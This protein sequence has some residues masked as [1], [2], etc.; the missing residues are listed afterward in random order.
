MKAGAERVGLGAGNKFVRVYG[1]QRVDQ[2]GHA[3]AFFSFGSGAG[4]GSV[5]SACPP[6]TAPGR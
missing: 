4:P 5:A 6:A 3:Q 2:S 1:G